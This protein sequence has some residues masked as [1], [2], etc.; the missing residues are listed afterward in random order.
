M[1][2]KV[3]VG[4]LTGSVGTDEEASRSGRDVKVEVEE[5]RWLL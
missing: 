3:S 4:L 2:A 5:E 1:R